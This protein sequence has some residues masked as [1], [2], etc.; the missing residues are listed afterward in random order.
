MYTYTCVYTYIYIYIYTPAPTIRR[1]PRRRAPHAPARAGT[2]RC[3]SPRL[4]IR[5]YVCVIYIYIYIY[6]YVRLFT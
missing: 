3:P 6:I 1:P 5:A 4:C 2:S